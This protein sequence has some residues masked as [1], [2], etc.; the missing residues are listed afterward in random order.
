MIL[1]A[2]DRYPFS[3]NRISKDYQFDKIIHLKKEFNMGYTS[4]YERI[5]LFFQSSLSPDKVKNCPKKKTILVIVDKENMY[6]FF[7]ML[8]KQYGE[9]IGANDVLSEP[10][11]DPENPNG[12]YWGR[13]VFDLTF[14]VIINL[15]FLNMIFG[16]ILYKFSELRCKR[17]N[18][19]EEINERCFI[20]GHTQQEIETYTQ[21]GWFYHIY[22][23][24]NILNLMFYLIYLDLKDYDKCNKTEKYVKINMEKL[25]VSFISF[26]LSLLSLARISTRQKNN[27]ENLSEQIEQSNANININQINPQLIKE[28]QEQP[29]NQLI[30]TNQNLFK[31]A[32]KR[33]QIKLDTNY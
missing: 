30:K 18:I 10:Q 16:I 9:G 31:R 29:F 2:I 22:K 26:N 6:N 27:N 5:Q 19:V 8:S 21:N 17:Q 20:C 7:Y 3:I 23:E 11:Y 12:H 33:K 24:H 15:L 4:I 25:Q 1:C 32:K 28:N 14:Y 13:Y